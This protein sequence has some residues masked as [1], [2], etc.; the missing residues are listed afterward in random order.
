M[1]LVTPPMYKDKEVG[2]AKLDLGQCFQ[3]HPQQILRNLY[4]QQYILNVQ[5]YIRSPQVVYCLN[6]VRGCNSLCIV[7][8]LQ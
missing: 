1:N 7:P 3:G 5:R 6:F 8:H 4:T 2:E